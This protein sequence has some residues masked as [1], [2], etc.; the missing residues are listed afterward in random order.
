[1]KKIFLTLTLSVMTCALF[2]QLKE[3]HVAYK[4]ETST[5]NPDMQMAVGMMQGSTMEVYFKE[6]FTR[7][8][9]KMG[10]MM[11]MTTISN[12]TTG[13]VLMLMSG[14][15]GQTAVKSN[16]KETAKDTVLNKKPNVDVT[17]TGETKDI[18]GYTCKKALITD[19][20][21]TISTFWYTEDIRAAKSGQSYLSEDVPG[22]PMEFEMNNNGMKMTMTVTKVDTKVSGKTSDLFDMNI[23]AGYTEM[24]LDQLKQMGMGGN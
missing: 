11:T 5:D 2:A 22:F 19:E 4:I 9:F 8:E 16:S 13:D 12:E 7:G 24:S 6:S 3:G 14:M 15:M 20:E 23:P 21:G 1:M 17:L 18:Q 10:A